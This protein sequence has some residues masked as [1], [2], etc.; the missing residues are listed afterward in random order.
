LALQL[1]RSEGIQRAGFQ[2]QTGF[3]VDSLAGSALERQTKIG[4][5]LDD[6]SSVRLTRRGQ[7]VADAVIESLL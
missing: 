4:L 3:Q 6:G 2:A 1:R 7:Y 5:L